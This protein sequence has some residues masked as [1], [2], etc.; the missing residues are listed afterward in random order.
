MKDDDSPESLDKAR[1]RWETMTKR[2]KINHLR[3]CAEWARASNDDLWI[4]L[5]DTYDDEA[6][7]IQAGEFDEFDEDESP[8]QCEADAKVAK[9]MAEL[10]RRYDASSLAALIKRKA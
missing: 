3:R 2:Q 7:R 6:D 9:T 8:E 4:E 5:A 10:L 1:K